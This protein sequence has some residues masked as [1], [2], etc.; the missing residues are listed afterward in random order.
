MEAGNRWQINSCQLF[1]LRKERKMLGKLKDSKGFTLIEL[2]IVFVILGVLAQMA[3]TFMIDLRTRS[4]DVSAVADGKNLI[5]LVR[6]NAVTLDDVDYTKI[7]G[8]DVGVE[9][10]GGVARPPIFTLS[11][12]VRIVVTGGSECNG[13]PDTSFFEAWLYH[14]NG[15]DDPVSTTGCGNREFY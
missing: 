6:N 2:F 12:G 14:E 13:I 8:S 5:T 15:T 9:T 11:P 7:N 1:W 10:T 3:W 4:F